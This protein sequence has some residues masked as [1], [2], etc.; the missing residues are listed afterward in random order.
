[1]EPPPPDLL[2][3]GNKK[4]ILNFLLDRIFTEQLIEQEYLAVTSKLMDSAE[5]RDT[6]LSMLE[7][8]YEG[9]PLDLWKPERAA[10]MPVLLPT[11][12]FSNVF[13]LMSILL[14]K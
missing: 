1:M 12:V 10:K 7:K 8:D 13:Q 5:N 4:A 2:D 6:A 9:Y 14:G 11:S 3:Y